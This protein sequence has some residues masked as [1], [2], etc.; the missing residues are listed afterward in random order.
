M[1]NTAILRVVVLYFMLSHSINI[2]RIAKMSRAQVQKNTGNKEEG[3][4][5]T[6]KPVDLHY[7]LSLFIVIF[8]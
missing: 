4:N 6:L 5:I 3:K 8:W 2:C 7:F 1:Y